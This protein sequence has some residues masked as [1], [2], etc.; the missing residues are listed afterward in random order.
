MQNMTKMTNNLLGKKPVVF[1]T[2]IQVHKY[3]RYT[4]YYE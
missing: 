4:Q 1:I 2:K 3:H